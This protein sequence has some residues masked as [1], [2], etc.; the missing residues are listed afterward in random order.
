MKSVF[1]TGPGFFAADSNKVLPEL[2]DG[3]LRIY[4]ARIEAYDIEDQESDREMS[5][6]VLFAMCED[7]PEL[8]RALLKLGDAIGANEE[9]LKSFLDK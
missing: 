9:V 3:V 1:Q 6:K 4:C 5:F 8:A 2:E 7:N